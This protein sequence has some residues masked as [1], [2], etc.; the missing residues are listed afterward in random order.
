MVNKNVFNTEKTDYETPSLFLGQAPGLV[1]TVNKKYPKI[2]E[3]YK[4]M[5]DLDWAEDEFDYS[6]CNTEFKTCSKA[7]YEMMIKTLAWQWEADSIASRSI[8]PIVAPFVSSSELWIAWQRI[9]DNECFVDGTEILTPNGWVDFADLTMDNKVAQ[10]NLDGT[11][12][13]VHPLKIIDKQYSG[14]VYEFT[15]DKGHIQQTVTPNHRMYI[16]ENKN[17]KH[18]IAYASDDS[19]NTFGSGV[20]KSFVTGGLLKG[21]INELSPIDRFIIAAQAD[22][23]ISERYTGEKIGTIPIWFTFSKQRKIERLLWICEDANID[24]IELTGSES[25]DNKQAQ[26]RFKANVPVKYKEYMKNFTLFNLSDKSSVWCREFLYEVGQWDGHI[27]KNTTI[28]VT[29][30]KAVAEFCQAVAAC[31]GYKTHF[32]ENEDTRS[33]TFNNTFRITWKDQD[34][35]SFHNSTRRIQY[36]EGRVRCVSVDSG[37][38]IVRYKGAV[39]VS[40]NSVHALTYSEIVRNS[41]DNPDDVLDEVLRIEQSFDR[42]EGVSKIFAE[43]FTIGHRYALG[44]MD[45]DE[46][47]YDAAFMLTVALLILERLQ[48]MASF[49]VTFA[50]CD[51]GMFQ[52]IGK[53]VQKIA[54]DELEIHVELDKAVIRNEMKTERGRASYERN[55]DRIKSLIDEVVGSEFKWIEYLFSEG[56]E[57]VGLNEQVLKQW[58]LFCARDVYNFMDVKSEHTLPRQNPLRFMANWLDISKTQSSPQEQENNQ[59]K[60]GIISRNDRGKV[61]E[62]D[63]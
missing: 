32:R 33:D 2:F 55:K 59:Y 48:F 3:I 50:I 30:N 27:T 45:N 34:Y 8:A 13:F 44:E 17:M 42:L 61:Y 5:K 35:H 10:Y 28:L 22:G 58:T 15:T 41:F 62:T 1:D 31:A 36:Y 37:L 38:I 53:A 49:A 56:R 51:S 54:Q 23:S 19:M 4:A 46:T 20:G 14:D 40:G 39:S 26:R 25:I 24:L 63:F 11:V 7:T 29:T 21:K 12:D 9:S 6:P 60:M 57:L 43:A 47:V 18:T 16:R 52:P